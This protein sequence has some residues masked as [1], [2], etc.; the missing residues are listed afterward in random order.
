[1]TGL[2]AFMADRKNLRRA[3]FSTPALTVAVLGL[4]LTALLW[5]GAR[6]YVDD[7]TRAAFH[8]ETR[9]IVTAIQQQINVQGEVLRGMQGFFDSSGEVTR[10]EFRRYV[11]QLAL[12]ERYPGTQMFAFARRVRDADR[13]GY[14]ARLRRELAAL[15]VSGFALHPAGTRDEYL[16]FEYVHPF[17]ANTM[18]L[19]FDLLSD[20]ARHPLPVQTQTGASRKSI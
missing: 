3:L 1:M 6:Q 14:E 16:P 2:S 5:I 9:D 10:D 4:L 12:H 19:G 15:G 18:W 11:A 13:A 17:S 20:P 8:E 7:H